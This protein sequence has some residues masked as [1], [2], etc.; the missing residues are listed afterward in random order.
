MYSS[1]RLAHIIGNGE[2]ALI[3]RATG[4]AD[5]IPENGAAF[6]GSEEEF[7][8][9]LA[10]YKNNADARMKAARK[11]YEAFYREFDNKTVTAY[12]AAL[13]SGTFKTPERPWQIVI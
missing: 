9:K 4:F 3:D 6:Y 5:I 1:D 12:M 2:L 8:D 10:F 7:Y 11:G 13:L